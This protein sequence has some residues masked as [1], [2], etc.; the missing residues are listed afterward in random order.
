VTAA[1]QPLAPLQEL[2]YA[3]DYDCE[4]TGEVRTI[5]DLLA[6][7][8]AASTYAYTD[9]SSPNAVTAITG[10]GATSS[11]VYDAAGRMT[12]RTVGATGMGL[13]RDV[14]SNLVA[15]TQTGQDRV[16]LGFNPERSGARPDYYKSP[17]D[18]I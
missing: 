6:S 1:A 17:R 4:S 14:S 10:G 15:T 12:T 5:T 11:Y 16:Y 2:G 3:L 18:R 13:V 9:T 7:T 8:N